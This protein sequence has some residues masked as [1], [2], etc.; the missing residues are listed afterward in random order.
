MKKVLI[1][2]LTVV[3]SLSLFGCSNSAEKSAAK[4]VSNFT[5][6]I[7]K[8]D[9]KQA[10]KY[11]QGDLS[12]YEVGD[13]LNGAFEVLFSSLTCKI[14]STQKTDDKDKVIVKAEFTNIACDKI[15]GEFTKQYLSW[16]LS[17]AL[18]G[19]NMSEKETEKQVK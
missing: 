6:A 18:S 7:S 9:F 14:I 10:S 3:M 4:T 17:T 2:L 15:I 13:K 11:Y 1:V 16:A 19:E 12:N 8:S 5:K